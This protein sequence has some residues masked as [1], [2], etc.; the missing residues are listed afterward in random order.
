MV[1]HFKQHFSKYFQ[2]LIFLCNTYT[3]SAL[4]IGKF[5][6]K[7][8]SVFPH[9]SIK[10]PLASSALLFLLPKLCIL[11]VH[12]NKNCQGKIQPR[13][14]W[15]E[16]IENKNDVLLFSGLTR[17]CRRPS[18]LPAPSTCSSCNKMSLGSPY[19][20]LVSPQVSCADWPDLGHWGMSSVTVSQSEASNVTTD[21][22]EL[23]RLTD[24]LTSSWSPSC[25]RS[26]ICERIQRILSPHSLKSDIGEMKLFDLLRCLSNK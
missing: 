21:Q 3:R 5:R 11:A 17:W 4:A 13:M 16:V 26:E 22:W 10:S 9:A 12:Q 7:R 18:W 15:N 25:S 23:S 14:N 20:K 24:K 6:I 2:S 1:G 8:P 19:Y